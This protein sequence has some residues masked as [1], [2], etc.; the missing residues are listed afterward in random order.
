MTTKIEGFGIVSKCVL[1]KLPYFYVVV[2]Y[3]ADI[4]RFEGICNYSMCPVLNYFINIVKCFDLQKV[5]SKCLS[6]Y[7]CY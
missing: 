3:Y 4:I 7:F 5:N 1:N 2:S 6:Q